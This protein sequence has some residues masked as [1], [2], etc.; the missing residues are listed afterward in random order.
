MT[1]SCINSPK[2]PIG[3]PLDIIAFY[4]DSN[5]HRTALFLITVSFSYRDI[6]CHFAPRRRDCLFTNSHSYRQD[7]MVADEGFEPTDVTTFEVAADASFA[8]LRNHSSLTTRYPPTTPLPFR[9]LSLVRCDE[10]N[11]TLV[12]AVGLEPTLYGV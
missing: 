3:N 4:G 7:K 11:V 12:G 6:R 10:Q 9:C 1:A 5:H 8:N 2:K